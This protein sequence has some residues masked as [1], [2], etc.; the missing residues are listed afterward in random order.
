M[1]GSEECSE[2]WTSPVSSESSPV[3]E[4]P[5]LPGSPEVRKEYQGA[6]SQ[7][8]YCPGSLFQLKFGLFP[9][10]STDDS[11]EAMAPSC[12]T[13]CFSEFCTAAPGGIVSVSLKE[14]RLLPCPDNPLGISF[15][16]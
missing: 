8:E 9:L 13:A 15:G 16:P 11:P 3:Q 5:R 7:A 12:F 1:T 6:E 10:C 14:S 2:H 4:A